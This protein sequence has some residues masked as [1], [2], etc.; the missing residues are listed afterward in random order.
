MK[1]KSKKSRFINLARQ[2]S[3]QN[4]IVNSTMDSMLDHVMKTELIKNRSDFEEIK[5]TAI[6]M[7]E[8]NQF[9]DSIAKTRK[10]KTLLPKPKM[11][12]ASTVENSVVQP[13]K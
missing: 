8:W 5:K 12:S 7:G 10:T 9:S 2:I 1:R 6:Q 13:N 3:L 11:N 4:G